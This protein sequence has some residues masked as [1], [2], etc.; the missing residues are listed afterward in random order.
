VTRDRPDN[1]LVAELQAAGIPAA[2]IG[3]A[4]A[5]RNL[6]SAIGDGF[7]WESLVAAK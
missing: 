1:A 5:P 2:A 7:R 6:R 4:L 3:D